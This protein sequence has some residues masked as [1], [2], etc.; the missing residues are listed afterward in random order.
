MNKTKL[1]FV[2]LLVL[3][4]GCL[5]FC[6]CDEDKPNIPDEGGEQETLEEVW[7]DE[8]FDDEPYHIYYTSNGDG[9][10]YVSDITTNPNNLENYT[11][12]IPEKSPN[13]DVV[14]AIS[15]KA[16]VSLRMELPKSLPYMMTESTYK[17]LISAMKENST[18]S[19][20]DSHRIT[21]FQAF[22][23]RLDPSQPLRGKTSQEMLAEYPLLQYTTLYKLDDTASSE[24]LDFLSGVLTQYA[25]SYAQDFEKKGYS[26]LIT[27]AKDHLEGDEFCAS[28]YFMWYRNADHMTEI[29][30]PETVVEI[31]S[32]SFDNCSALSA[33]NIPRSIARIGW[34][35]FSNCP[36]LTSVDFF[37][38]Q[39]EWGEIIANESW[40]NDWLFESSITVVHCTDGDVP[41]YE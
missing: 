15:L 11:L 26:E 14:V 7:V 5:L 34:F 20:D 8:P 29:E 12:I 2:A 30:L 17:A 38:S 36:K 4:C 27:L 24:D 31:E 9:T 3:L 18:G 6:A 40:S 37:G 28:L 1:L 16:S 21:R 19:E 10:C 13:G 41:L 35:A 32:Y 23:E 25:P 22:Y 33:V 39:S